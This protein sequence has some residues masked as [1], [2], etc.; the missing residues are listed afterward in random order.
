M[1]KS[2]AI[3]KV[4]AYRMLL[5]EHFNM[6]EVYLFGSYA[7]DTYNEDSDI[8]VAIVVDQVDG[9]YFTVNPLL[10][11]VR[12]QI[13]DRIEPILIERKYDEGNFLDEV[14]KSGIEIV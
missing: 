2:E 3:S 4:K 8:D 11:K 6:Y 13:D 1:D 10:W 12:R 14:K 5:K 7:K 9:D